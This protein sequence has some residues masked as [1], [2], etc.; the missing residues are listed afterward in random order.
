MA[1]LTSYAEV[2]ARD[3]NAGSEL[4]LSSCRKP[5]IAAVA[6]YALGGG[7]ELA[8]MCDF[9]LAV[10]ARNVSRAL[11]E[12][13]KRWKC[14]SLGVSMDANEAER[15]GL[16]ARVVSVA[17]LLNEAVRTAT[18]IA[19]LSR[20]VTM[21]HGRLR[22]GR[23]R[24]RTRRRARHRCRRRARQLFRAVSAADAGRQARLATPM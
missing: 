9:I 6:G 23:G 1:Q 21:Q 3:F 12:K 10:A 11:S 19:S 13:P 5:V 16:V 8:T 22:R 24:R 20:P 15:A 18:K 2:F 14:A 17:D 7:C 4:R